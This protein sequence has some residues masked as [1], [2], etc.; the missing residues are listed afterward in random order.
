MFPQKRKRKTTSS[1]RAWIRILLIVLMAAPMTFIALHP[2]F[3]QSLL[4]DGIALSIGICAAVYL[5][6]TGILSLINHYLGMNE[7]PS[8]K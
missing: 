6:H 8:E 7:L 3:G 2:H 5:V 4:A 1:Y